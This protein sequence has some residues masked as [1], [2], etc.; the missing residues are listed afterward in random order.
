M[1]FI[2][3]I[4]LAG[5]AYWFLGRKKEATQSIQPDQPSSLSESNLYKKNSY[6]V[7]MGIR[8]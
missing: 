6:S 3:L 4:A 2:G 7:S 1:N 5:T 8:G